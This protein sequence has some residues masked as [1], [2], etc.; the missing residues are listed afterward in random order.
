M[1]ILKNIRETLSLSNI[2]EQAS[3][4]KRTA[5]MIENLLSL[6]QDNKISSSV[7]DMLN[8]LK[9]LISDKPN[10]ASINHYINHFLLKLNPENQPIVLKELLE[11]FHERWKHVD[12][13]TAQVAYNL[14]NFK[15]KRVA[16]FGQS[17]SMLALI[18]LCVVNQSHCQVIQVL[19][20]G[21]KESQNQALQI[22]KKGVQVTVVDIYN[23]SRL[24]DKV[25]FLILGS[26]II[27]HEEFI[28][29]SGS[30]LLA[31]WARLNS[32]PVLVLSDS[33]K[34]LNKKILP[35][36]VIGT[37]IGETPKSAK[38]IWRAVPDN[39]EVINYHQE[40][41]EN[42]MVDFFILENQAY[43]PDELY[44]EVDKILVSK[45]I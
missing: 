11:V 40:T 5:Q 36:R 18:D 1:D 24:R 6:L 8:N 26:D 31:S 10:I 25:D 16:F 32:V 33:R 22:R 37:F 13:K 38:E 7:K 12:R 3:A 4:A 30:L 21:D 27:M 44:Q 2:K 34:I 29:K 45:F 43:R 9:I 28:S 39:I 42:K 35:Q 17:D 14:Y 15:G 20:R 23:F 41:V 19:N